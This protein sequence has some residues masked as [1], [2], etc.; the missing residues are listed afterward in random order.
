MSNKVATQI[1]NLSLPVRLTT[2]HELNRITQSNNYKIEDFT[3]HISQDPVISLEFIKLA[4]LLEYATSRNSICN[5]KSAVIRVGSDA[6]KDLLTKLSLRKVFDSPIKNK[7]LSQYWQRSSSAN[8][9]CKIF[10]DIT[11]ANF[12]QE[13]QVACLLYHIGDVVGLSYLGVAYCN[14]SNS[15]SR[16]KFLHEV[17]KQYKFNPDEVGIEYLLKHGIPS[18]LVSVLDR[19]GRS[20]EIPQKYAELRT[21]IHATYEIID[22]FEQ[23]KIKNYLTK[24]SLPNSSSLRLLKLQDKQ[25]VK[26]IERAIGL[27]ETSKAIAESSSVI[28]SEPIHSNPSSSQTY[29]SNT[30]Q[31]KETQF[32]FIAS[33]DDL[34]ELFGLKDSATKRHYSRA[35]QVILKDTVKRNVEITSKSIEK[36]AVIDKI[37]EI[38]DSSEQFLSLLLEILIQNGF[39]NVALLV[40]SFDNSCA[41]VPAARGIN[42]H[43]GSRVEIK[44]NFI[45][46]AKGSSKVQSTKT[47]D[48]KTSLFGSSTFAV[49]ALEA[50]HVTPVCLYADCGKD[51]PISF[52]ARRVFRHAILTINEHLPKLSGGL[53]VEV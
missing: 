44:D 49:A 32:F 45:L 43:S 40:L 46:I 10:F 1:L 52:E 11:G 13:C 18:E 7:W 2:L 16:A 24:D 33:N 23:N 26:I 51:I 25:L 36:Y 30:T 34:E 47:A 27:L 12:A 20:K 50:D 28:Q 17:T 8:T 37:A 48:A 29:N 4:N 42:I 15:L 3:N 5:L 53:P 41:F 14:L 9:I 39:R 21:V 31:F 38:S 6:S 19:Y 35:N 22:A